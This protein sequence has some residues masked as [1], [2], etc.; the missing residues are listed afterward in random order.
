MVA[1]PSSIDLYG[2]L[3]SR[4]KELEAALEEQGRRAIP[5]VVVPLTPR[6]LPNFA[7]VGTGD[8]RWDAA[9]SNVERTFWEG[10]FVDVWHPKLYIDGSWGYS[11]GA[12]TVTYRLYTNIDLIGTWTETTPVDRNVGPF[13]LT[14]YLRTQNRAVRLTVQC[15]G[16]NPANTVFVSPYALIQRR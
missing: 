16:N 10:R 7:T 13:D 14:S 2:Q 1:G 4:I 5:D 8:M 9:E 6:F 3:T 11:A 15:S 12:G